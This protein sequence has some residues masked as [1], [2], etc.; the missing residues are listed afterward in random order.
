MTAP[1]EPGRVRPNW[2]PVILGLG[3]AIG[4]G[5][6][7]AVVSQQRPLGDV[8][9]ADEKGSKSKPKVV[10]P[11]E[12]PPAFDRAPELDGGVAWLNTG[13]PLALKDLKGKVVL[14][15]FWTLC[16]INCIHTSSRTSPGSRRNIPNEL[17]VIGVHSAKFENEKNSE[18]IRKAIL[19]Y[20][21]KHPVVNDANQRI[22]DRYQRH[23]VADAGSHRP[24][25]QLPGQDFRR[26]QVR[27]ARQAS[28]A[29]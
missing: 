29:S 4:I 15:D 20:E 19:R 22:W 9:Q 21:I 25:R 5:I 23:L 10:D 7:L 18:T 16:C 8:A 17:V 12:P 2:L 1:A 26:R 3:L 11:D 14:L 27:F 24:G 28:S 13:K 6:T